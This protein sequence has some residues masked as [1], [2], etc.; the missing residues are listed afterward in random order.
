MQSKE[1]GKTGVFLPEIGLGTWD[2]KGGVEPLRKGLDAGAL[3]IDTAESYGTETIVG[4][5]IRGL[6]ERVFIATKVSPRNF[7]KD[8]LRKSVESSLTKLG[9]DRIDLL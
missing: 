5:A 1:L 3:F 4:E 7:R 2:Y 8:D 9:V 6:R